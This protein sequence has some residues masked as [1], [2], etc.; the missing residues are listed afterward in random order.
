MNIDEPGRLVDFIASSLPSLST[1]DKQEMLE[2]HRRSRAPGEDQP[3]SGEGTRSPATAQQDPVAKCRSEVQQTQREFYLREQMKAIQKELG[4]QDEGAARRRGT[5]QKIEAAGMPDEVK[6]EALKELSRLSRMSPMA[7]DY[8]VTRTYL[9]WMAVLPWSK[10]SGGEVDIPKAQGDSGRRPLRSGEGEGPHSG[11][12]VRAAVEADHEG[13]DPVLRRTSGRGQDF[14]GPVDRARAGTQ[15]RAH[16]AGRHARRSGDSRTSPHLHR[17]AAGADHSGHSPRRDATIRSSCWTKWT[18]WGAISAAI[19]RRRC[20]KCSIPSRTPRSATTIST[21]RSI[22]RRCCS[23][24]R[25]TCSIRLPEPLRDRMEII[26][27]QGYTEAGEGAHRLPV[28]DSAA[29][30]G[31]RPRRRSRSN[32]PKRRCAS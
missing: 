19:R 28:P 18:S 23:S 24:P 32:S 15:V 13:A 17:R 2:T 29:D 5:A 20:S 4:E 12:P 10:S 21:C 22:C 1:P 14:A 25:R 26:E 9:E 7:P 16:L 31:E 6:N 27:L 11:L 30:R 8:G 3:A